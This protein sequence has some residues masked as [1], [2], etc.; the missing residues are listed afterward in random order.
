L[1]NKRKI[2]I[3][4]GTG[5]IGYHL[6]NF[7]IK[8][9]WIVHSLSKSRPKKNRKL[10]KVKYILCDIRDKKKLKKRLDYY[11]D[12]IVNLSGYVDHSNKNSIKKI[13]F[14]GYKNLILN[15]KLNEPKKFIQ[16]GSSIEYGKIK[17]PQKEI[18]IKNK[19]TNSN[20]GN[21]K[22]SSTLHLLDFS[23]KN[24][25]PGTIIR[26][27]LVYGPNQDE[28]RVIPFVI[29]N[30]IKNKKFNCS[31]GIQFRDFTYID[32]VIQ[33]IYKSLNSKRSNGELINVGFGKPYKIKYLIN[34][35]VKHVGSGKPIFSKMK[36]RK[37]EL[38]SLYP[39]IRKSK[40]IL[41]WEPKISLING[42][43]KTI[44]FY[45]NQ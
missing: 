30:S 13:H 9:G 19:N 42:I 35:I 5:F 8:K 21:A 36:L 16:I 43:K 32:D 23:K 25:F 10:E 26:L 2:L 11:Y 28:N 44:K 34:M 39:S 20:Y 38:L 24:N 6:C 45:R 17:S 37:D 12:Y 27:Y 7:C 33:A 40:K 31:S 3:P 22:L 1:Q 41:N 14:G 4:G 18:Q 15:F 29:K